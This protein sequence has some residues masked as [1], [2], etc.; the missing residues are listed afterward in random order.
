VG[1]EDLFIKELKDI[2]VEGMEMGW[3]EESCGRN[4]ADV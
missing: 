1:V 2:V 3:G 4:G